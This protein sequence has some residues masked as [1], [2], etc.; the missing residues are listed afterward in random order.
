MR[1]ACT[2]ASILICFG[3]VPG[4]GPRPDR[5]L[6][7]HPYGTRGSTLDVYLPAGDPPPGGWPAFVVAPG[8]GWRWASKAELG[9]RLA[10]LTARG[11]AVVAIDYVYARPGGEPTFP[12]A[13]DDVRDAIRWVR[14][15]AS[16]LGVDPAKLVG[17]GQSAGGNVLLLAALDGEAAGEDAR[18]A[19][20]VSFYAPLDLAALHRD[21]AKAR[22]Y[23]ETYLGGTPDERPGR[24]ADAS[25]LSHVSPGD[26]PVFLTQG[27][28]DD[29]IA[30]GQTEAMARA[31]GAAGVP[32]E[33]LLLQGAPHGYVFR[34]TSRNMDRVLRFVEAAL[35]RPD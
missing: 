29:V 18:L 35:R 23:V 24:Y 3:C 10:G 16:Q 15:N 2:L 6:S 12:A 7:E 27:T 31:L 20:V 14:R 5:A 26:P 9:G 1:L 8:G 21:S 22:P 25:P 13:V 34:P 11:Y 4:P 32:H 30:V 28:A 33:V 17:L 19:A